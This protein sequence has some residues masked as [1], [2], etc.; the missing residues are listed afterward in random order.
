MSSL[1]ADYIPPLNQ[2][3]Y[4]QSVRDIYTIFIFLSS[5]FSLNFVTFERKTYFKYDFFKAYFTTTDCYN[6]KNF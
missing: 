2:S 5:F 4:N 3:S 6:A 1:L